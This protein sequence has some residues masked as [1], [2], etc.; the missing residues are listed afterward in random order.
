MKNTKLIATLLA[1]SFIAVSLLTA[2]KPG[3]EIFKQ[4]KDEIHNYKSNNIKPQLD[5]WKSKIDNSISS[6]DLIA[7]NKLREEAKNMRD[8]FAAKMKEEMDCRNEVGSGGNMK[9]GKRELGKMGDKHPELFR[10]LV[11]NTLAIAKKYPELTEELIAEGKEKHEEWREDIDEIIEAWKNSNS[12]FLAD[13]KGK[14]G[15]HKHAKGPGMKMPHLYPEMMFY[16][17][18]GELPEPRSASGRLINKDEGTGIVMG[19]EDIE[20][21]ETPNFLAYPNPFTESVSVDFWVP[22]SQ[23]VTVKVQDINGREVGTIS[24]GLMNEGINSVTINSGSLN[25]VPGEYFYTIQG[26]GFQ[27]RGRIV[28]Q[29]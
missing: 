7:L 3:L 11:D 15:I 24:N 16:L 8:K 21:P 17:Y 10:E 12:D 5:S 20:L 4:L 26:A 2:Q 6:E 14:G 23:N 18:N 19:I 29:K 25:L 22:E 13:F 27:Y 28:Y 9:H 1:F